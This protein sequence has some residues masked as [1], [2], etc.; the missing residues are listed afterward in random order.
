MP[1]PNFVTCKYIHST[2]CLRSLPSELWGVSLCLNCVRFN[3]PSVLL[4]QF[5]YLWIHSLKFS[6]MFEIFA[7]WAVGCEAELN[8]CQVN[9]SQCNARAQ[10]C[11]WWTCVYTAVGILTG[12]WTYAKGQVHLSQCYAR[13]QSTDRGE[14]PSPKPSHHQLLQ[15]V[16]PH[17]HISTLDWSLVFSSSRGN[18]C[19]K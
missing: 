4:P 1:E 10:L 15:N 8:L 14:L 12:V 6:F 11:I 18:P 13:A 2:L 17:L 7:I 3:C 9:L 19:W 5:C 16:P